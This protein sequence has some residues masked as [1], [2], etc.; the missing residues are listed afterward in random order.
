MSDPAVSFR[1]VSKR[2]RIYHEYNQTL[3]Q[4]ILRGR[5]SVH[6]DFLA[7]DSISFDVEAGT[8][9]GVIGS[10]G[11]GKS[12]LL[13]LVAG[14]LAPDSGSI[15]TRGRIG[16]LLELGAGFHGELTGRENIYLNG[17]LL[18]MR[19]R[20][21]EARFDEIVSFSGIGEHLDKAVKTYSSGMTARLGFSVAIHVDPEVLL[22]D[23]VLAVGDA[24]FQQ[25]CR[26]KIE[27]FKGQGRTVLLVSHSLPDVHR[28]CD[29][30]AWIENGRVREQGK[31]DEVLSAY[32]ASDAVLSERTGWLNL[33][34]TITFVAA[35]GDELTNVLASGQ[36]CEMS[37]EVVGADGRRPK[38]VRIGFWSSD[39]IIVGSVDTPPDEEVSRDGLHV[40]HF[41]QLPF[42]GGPL[43]VTAHAISEDNVLV[44]LPEAAR[45]MVVEHPYEA[46]KDHG[47]VVLRGAWR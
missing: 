39:G 13:K 42:L 44:E 25:R 43:L 21:V 33:S 41:D 30:V 32:L 27:E 46:G 34:V 29:A 24:T 18:G 40:F 28:L 7:I 19:K 16:A 26:R 37:V 14:I 11:A 9:F 15:T 17:T 45:S 35:S 2:Y 6:D 36:S 3:K 20:E 23:E 1:D 38:A 22:L 4:R 47:L 12:T 10:N 8:T 31:S 5:T